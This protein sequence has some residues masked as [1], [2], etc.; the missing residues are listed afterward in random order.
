MIN[1]YFNMAKAIRF[2][3]IDAV[4]KAASGHPGMP[5]GMAD[6]ATVLF[7]EFLRHNPSD[8]N[9]F[10][11][12][13]FILSNGHGSMLLYSILYLTGYI[14]IDEIKNFR[15]LGS[16]TPGHP[17]YGLTPGVE[18]TT[19]PLGQG[20]AC[21][22]GMAIAE[23]VL[24]ERFGPDLVNHHTYVMLGDGCL[25]EGVSSEAASLAGHLKLNKLIAIFDDNNISI[26]GSVDLAL[27]DD[28]TARFLSYGWN[29]ESIDG[30]NYAQISSAIKNA[31]NSD[32]PSLIR[33]KTTIGKFAAEYA[34]KSCAHSG[35][36]KESAVLKMRQDL[37]WK[38][39]PFIIPQDML[40][41]WRK[42]VERARSG[43][44]KYNE[45]L[46]SN[47]ELKRIIEKPPNVKEVLENLK[48]Q[49]FNL[50][51][52]EATRRSFGRV[53]EE[54]TKIM[55]ELIGGS[56]DLSDSNCTKYPHMQIISR[57]NF[58]GSYIHFGV[59]EHAM[60]ACMNGMAL[61]GGILPYGGTFL[62]FSDYCRPAIRLSALMKQQV[63]Y[64]MTHDSIGLGEDG[65]THQPVEHLASLRAIPNLLVFRPAD[66]L[67]TLE[68]LDIALSSKDSPSL[69]VLSR[70]NLNYMGRPYQKENLCEFGGYILSE[71]KDSLDVT[72][73]ATGSEV[74]IAIETKNKLQQKGIG[75]RVVS[76]PC[77]QLFDQ[78]SN[79]Y[80][81]EILNN[82]NIKAAV[83][84]GSSLGWHKYIGQDGIF[85]GMESFGCSAPYKKLYEHFNINADSLVKKILD[86]LRK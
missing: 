32:R 5:L 60:A 14:G 18:V 68:C 85:V 30:H 40:N 41:M 48:K 8:P 43:Y 31:H 55:P 39:E 16:K 73:F 67:E 57:N 33:C 52:S 26:D 76:M 29:V 17:E 63:I 74:E 27:S 69:F 59:R 2:L 61:H 42:T 1:D 22:V 58:N 49:I 15:Q 4:Q 47:A 56:A 35:P 64:V 72:I 45:K 6:V 12:D 46:N 36:F 21:S 65:P 50:K 80:K 66:A 70:Q 75:V 34:G 78:Q 13:R 38:H 86:K 37:N 9:W 84:A 53:M 44:E 79:K 25:M 10:N 28:I 20:F 77:W 7:S 19:G 51:P 54:L 82:N 23:A 24:R 71:Y 83:E 3:S 81:L 11:R 62:V